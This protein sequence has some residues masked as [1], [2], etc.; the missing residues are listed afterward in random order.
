VLFSFPHYFFFSKNKIKF[1]K[2]E[3]KEKTIL[4]E[5][6]DIQEIKTQGRQCR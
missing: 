4:K 5:G 1:K 6:K 2:I 3:G